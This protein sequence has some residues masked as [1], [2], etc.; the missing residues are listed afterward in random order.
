V[1]LAESGDLVYA[2]YND[3]IPY[4]QLIVVE[5]GRVAR[6][7]LDD[8]QD[9]SA[10]VDLGRLPEETGKPFKDWIEAMGWVEE[11]EEKLAHSEQGW[12]WIHQAD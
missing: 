8:E 3:T 10:N 2:G 6:Q 1:T 4:A 9:P 12:L 11:D 5:K 7:F